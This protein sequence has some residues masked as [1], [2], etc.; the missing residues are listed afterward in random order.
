MAAGPTL[1]LVW[2]LWEFVAF[3]TRS[4]ESSTAYADTLGDL[5]LGWLA[6]VLA[7]GL[8]PEPEGTSGPAARLLRREIVKA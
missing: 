8:V 3:V 2:E 1:S 5:A 4:A 7:A 6:A